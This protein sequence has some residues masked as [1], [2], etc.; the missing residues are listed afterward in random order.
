MRAYY[1]SFSY[2]INKALDVSCITNFALF[3]FLFC[4]PLYQ[5]SYSLTHTHV[6]YCRSISTLDPIDNNSATASYDFKNPI[7]QA[8][9]ECEDDCE[10]PGEL[11]RLL[12]QE[13]RAIPP[14]EEPV[15]TINMGTK[16]DRKEVKIGTIMLRSSPGHMK[17]CRD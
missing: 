12:Q 4:C 15:E 2:I 5:N 3:V 13:E 17:T 6:S 7:N 11:A 14:H 10:V 9:D 16:V 8:E 1:F